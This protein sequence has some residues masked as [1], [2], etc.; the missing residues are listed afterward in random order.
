[1]VPPRAAG[2]CGRIS[3]CSGGC[4]HAHTEQLSPGLQQ[5]TTRGLSCT[6]PAQG[7]SGSSDEPP[8]P[9]VSPLLPG[10]GLVLQGALGR[11]RAWGLLWLGVA[12]SPRGRGGDGGAPSTGCLPGWGPGWEK[13]G[14]EKHRV[15]APATCGQQRSLQPPTCGPPEQKP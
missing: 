10:P 12:H 1:M 15:L 7:P 9:R 6:E 4:V 3:C 11:G 13:G 14:Q 5:E 8:D 2:L